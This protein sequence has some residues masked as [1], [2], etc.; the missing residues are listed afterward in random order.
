MASSETGGIAQS[1]LDPVFGTWESLVGR[2]DAD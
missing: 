2:R 1:A